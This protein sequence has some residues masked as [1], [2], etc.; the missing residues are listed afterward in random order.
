MPRDHH[1]Q[2]LVANDFVGKTSVDQMLKQI[3]LTEDGG[4]WMVFDLQSTV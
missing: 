4:L 2:H 1:G 3:I